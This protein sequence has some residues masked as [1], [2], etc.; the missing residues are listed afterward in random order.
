MLKKEHRGRIQAQGGGLEESESWNQDEPLTKK[1]GLRM[2]RKLKEKL[3]PKE[4]EKRKKA[5]QS[6]ERFIKNTKGGL[7]ARK[8]RSF[9]DDKKNKH[10]RVDIEILGGKAFVTIIIIII[11]LGLWKLI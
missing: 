8:G 4:V 5:F 6:A 1:D 11:L 10:V 7:D 3:P 2:L 9:Y